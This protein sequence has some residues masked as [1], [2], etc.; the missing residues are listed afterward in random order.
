M[1]IGTSARVYRR[2]DEKLRYVSDELTTPLLPGLTVSLAET[3]ED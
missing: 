2:R 3:F 1:G